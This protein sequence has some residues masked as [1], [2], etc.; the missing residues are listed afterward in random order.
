MS[1]WLEAIAVWFKPRLPLG[2]E[3][4]FDQR[5]WCAIADDWNAKRS[6]SVVPG[7]D[8]IPGERVPLVD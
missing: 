2:L 8:I 1:P 3:G 7:L 5:L 4:E 6:F